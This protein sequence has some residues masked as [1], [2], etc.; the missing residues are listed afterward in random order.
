M[1]E[2]LFEKILFFHSSFPPDLQNMGEWG[3]NLRNTQLFGL[4]NFLCFGKSFIWSA[5]FMP[6]R[7]YLGWGREQKGL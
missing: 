5:H 7:A 4:D 3:R 6:K 1:E 2:E